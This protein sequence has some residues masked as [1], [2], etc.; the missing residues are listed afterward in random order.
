MKAREFVL[1]YFKTVKAKQ[2]TQGIN[3]GKKKIQR[4]KVNSQLR[5]M[6]SRQ[7]KENHGRKTNLA[8]SLVA[9][10]VSY[11]KTVFCVRVLAVCELEVVFFFFFFAIILIDNSEKPNRQTLQKLFCFTV[12]VT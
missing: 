11:F 5:K 7:N 8:N 2:S 9:G 12:H 10:Y 1:I 6:S 4:S 3:T